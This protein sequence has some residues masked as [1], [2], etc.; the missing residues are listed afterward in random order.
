[1]CA[2]IHINVVALKCQDFPVTYWFILKTVTLFPHPPQTT[3]IHSQSGPAKAMPGFPTAA[4]QPAD[5]SSSMRLLSAK[6]LETRGKC[7]KKG[8]LSAYRIPEFYIS[9]LRAMGT[10]LP[11]ASSITKNYATK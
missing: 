4:R 2:Q 11:Q 8:L 10:Y 5:S 9:S 3:Y 7:L 1:M 6:P